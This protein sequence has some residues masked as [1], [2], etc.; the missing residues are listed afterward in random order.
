MQGDNSHTSIMAPESADH[1]ARLFRDV[2]ARARKGET[3]RVGIIESPYRPKR[4]LA[5]GGRWVG[6]EAGGPEAEAGPSAARSTSTAGGTILLSHDCMDEVLEVSR[7]DLLAV[8]EGGVRYGTF[9]RAV[10]EAGLYFPHEPSLDMT[11]AEMVM[12]GTIL[13]TEGSFG[14]LR[15]YILGLEL[16]TP[17]GEIVRFGSRAVKD[18][19]GYELIGFL[20][21]RGGSC[22]MITN[23]TLRLLAE[24]CCRAYIAARG[25]LR[26]LKMLAYNARRSFRLAS[27][28]IFEG[29]AAECIERAWKAKLDG[30]G[31]RLPPILA[32]SGVSDAILVGELQGLENVVEDQLLSIAAT[33]GASGA[34]LVLLDDELFESSRRFPF[35]AGIEGRRAFVL[36]SYDGGSAGEAPPGSLIRRSLYPERIDVFVP[37]TDSKGRVQGSNAL[38]VIEENPA[39]CMFV[40]D[41]VGTSCRERVY[42]IEWN[43]GGA[44]RTRI[45]DGDLLRLA[46]PSA[47]EAEGQENGAGEGAKAEDSRRAP[48]KREQ[49]GIVRDLTH[50]IL[51]AFDPQAIMLP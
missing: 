19:G 33:E 27:T 26:I 17:E 43:G 25:D 1:A 9:A 46:Q 40:A 22:G 12:D 8:V 38:E 18:V 21:G 3:L 44:S 49:A 29:A 14:G 13:P 7:A 48:E 16:V 31:K 50:R 2:A 5:G 37:V 11:I 23:V 47:V 35:D 6:S 24:P 42:I 51:E 41:I 20:M 10:R 39:L 4:G 30:R 15:E 32:G 45:A 28:E 34:S 36:V